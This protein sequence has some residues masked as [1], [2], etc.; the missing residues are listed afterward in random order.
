MNN[1]ERLNFKM[2]SCFI[3]YSEFVVKGSEWKTEKDIYWGV[4]CYRQN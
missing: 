3:E 1:T 4:P 2:E